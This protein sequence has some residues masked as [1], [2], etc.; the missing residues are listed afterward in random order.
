MKEIPVREV[1]FARSGDKGNISNVHVHPYRSDD[2]D[3]LI[4]QL[5]V[6]R[7]REAFDQL[8]DGPI[9]RYVLPGTSS[10]NFVM[11]GALGGGVI[12]RSLNRDIH[13]KSRG[14]LLMSMSIEVPEDYQPPTESP[15]VSEGN[16][17]R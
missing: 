10:I 11:Y 4:E 3:L 15:H 7:V 13:G 6:D 9:E 2:Y 12:G 8:I 5:T 1:A 16:G 14:N 17:Q